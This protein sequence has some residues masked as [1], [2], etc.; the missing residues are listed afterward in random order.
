VAAPDL[1]IFVT[2]I[3]RAGYCIGRGAKPWFAANGLDFRDFM[4]NGIPAADL[5]ATGDAMAIRVVEQA[6]ERR[7]G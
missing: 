4:K 3:T 1:R 7:R 5:L 6:E 2:D